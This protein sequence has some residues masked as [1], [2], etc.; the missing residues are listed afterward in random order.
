MD[1]R[2]KISRPKHG[3]RFAFGLMFWGGHVKQK[4]QKSTGEALAHQC[5][6]VCEAG[7]GRAVAFAV[8]YFNLYHA[9]RLAG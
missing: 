2:N 7:S 4:M 5:D 6:S 8:L 1:V 3:L 9:A